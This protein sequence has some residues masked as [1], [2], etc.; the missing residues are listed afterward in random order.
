MKNETKNKQNRERKIGRLHVEGNTDSDM[1]A[2]GEYR[3]L[4]Q[5]E[6]RRPPVLQVR[7]SAVLRITAH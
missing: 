7:L 4:L 1:K 2:C 6:D 3:Q 5:V